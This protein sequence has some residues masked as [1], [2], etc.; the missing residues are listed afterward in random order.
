MYIAS[1]V[2]YRG[3][4]FLVMTEKERH[5]IMDDATDKWLSENGGVWLRAVQFSD[6]H[7][8]LPIKV[9][10]EILRL[11]GIIFP[12]ITTLMLFRMTF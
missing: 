3:K 7:S 1:S 8:E 2:L 10:D 5:R 11:D 4:F 12:D 6:I 9:Q